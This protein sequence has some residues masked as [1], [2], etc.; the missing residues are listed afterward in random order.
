MWLSPS[1]VEGA[2]RF[3][4][5]TPAQFLTE[6][7]EEEKHNW[8]RLKSRTFPP[9]KGGGEGCVFLDDESKCSIYEA[10]PLQC[11]TYPYWPRV[12]RSRE[13]WEDE[14]VVPDGEAGDEEA[15]V[16]GRRRWDPVEGGCEGIEN[17]EAGIVDFN[18]V[19]QQL[20]MQIG[21]NRALP[22]ERKA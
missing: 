9:E 3:L 22:S 12:M 16:T 10:R 21:Y 7:G 20:L 4:K 17:P 18:I 13:A 11:R 6:W 5:L 8:V 19:R 14:R 15:R 2:A 1:E